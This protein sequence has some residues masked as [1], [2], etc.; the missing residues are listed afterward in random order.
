MKTNLKTNISLSILISLFIVITCMSL[1]AD[2]KLLRGEGE[3][4]YS[5]N[6]KKADFY[7]SPTGNDKW[8]GTLEEPNSNMIDGPFATIERARLAVRKLKN[9]IYHPSIWPLLIC[10]R[11]R[12]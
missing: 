5:L 1:H 4:K 9:K 8:S 2:G 6:G 10:T 12:R 7:V 3:V 11:S